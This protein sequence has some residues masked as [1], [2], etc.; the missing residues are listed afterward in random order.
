MSTAK[1]VGVLYQRV[2]EDVMTNVREAFLDDGVDEQILIELRQAFLDD[3]VDE[4]IL[5][6]L[7][8]LWEK[9][10]AAT[11]ALEHPS[12]AK[13]TLSDRAIG[14]MVRAPASHTKQHRQEQVRQTALLAAAPQPSQPSQQSQ[15]SQPS[16]QSQQSQHTV[17]VML[18]ANQPELVADGQLIAVQTIGGQPTVVAIPHQLLVSGEALATPHVTGQVPAAT[19]PA[20]DHHTQ[21]SSTIVQLDG[22][23]DGSSSSEDDDFDN[24]NDDDN[25]DEQNDDDGEQGEDED[26]LNSNDD[27]SEEDSTEIFETDNVVVCQFDKINRNKNK[28]KFNLKDGIM[29][30]NGKDFV[31]H[32]ALGDAE[33]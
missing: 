4:Q 14:P 18:T 30:L 19:A 29:S 11:K 25:E 23:G 8:Q 26:P 15:Q 27:V 24:D 21:N 7:R 20:A 32:R 1:Q 6:E 28:W 2:V 3:G 31:F 9:K 13:R 12:E 10:L 16:Q 33:W 17:P 5:I 22:A